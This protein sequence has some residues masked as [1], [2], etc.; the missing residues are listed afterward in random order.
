MNTKVIEINFYIGVSTTLY[1]KYL[2]EKIKYIQ[3]K[4]MP[5]V[6]QMLPSTAIPVIHFVATPFIFDEGNDIPK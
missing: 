6:E 4:I 5:Y 1:K 3:D 2:Q